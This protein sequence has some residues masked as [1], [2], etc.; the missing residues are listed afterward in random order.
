MNQRLET[1]LTQYWDANLSTEEEAELRTLISK[2]SSHPFKDY[3]QYLDQGKDIASISNDFDEKLL[4]RLPNQIKVNWW[5]S[6]VLKVAASFLLIGALSV[7]AIYSPSWIEEDE[8]A[9]IQGISGEIEDPEVAYQEARK[10]LLMVSR[11]LN[12]ADNQL[13]EL[14]RIDQVVKIEN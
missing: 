6:S 4:E 7:M 14:N 8:I 13:V 2:E 10:A 1:L 3:F 9:Q 11:K 5:Q 12:S